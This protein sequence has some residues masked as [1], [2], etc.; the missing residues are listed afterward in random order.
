[1]G[2]TAM[3]CLWVQGLFGFQD[4]EAGNWIKWRIHCGPF[5]EGFAVDPLTYFIATMQIIGVFC[6]IV[7][8]HEWTYFRCQESQS[9]FAVGS[10]TCR[11]FCTPQNR[12]D[13]RDQAEK[14]DIMHLAIGTRIWEETSVVFALLA[15]FCRVCRDFAV[16]QGLWQQRYSIGIPF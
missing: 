9:W 2:W 15:M 13:F 6:Y 10:L 1:M 4:S 14:I 16:S 3:R 11:H 12:T 7:F 8:L 5:W